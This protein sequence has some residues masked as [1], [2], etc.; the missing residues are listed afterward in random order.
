MR[1]S[2][3]WTL[4]ISI[5]LLVAGLLLSGYGLFLNMDK[6]VE[7]SYSN[8]GFYYYQYHTKVS[9]NSQ[10][11]L[12]YLVYGYL[13]FISGLATMGYFV[14]LATHPVE[15]KKVQAKKEALLKEAP[16]PHFEKKETVVENVREREERVHEEDV[17]GNEACGACKAEAEP[18]DTE[19]N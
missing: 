7:R 14:Y 10:L 1:T 2:A 13:I 5:V 19:A 17:S 15:K 6:I 18:V 9:G 4:A 16:Q 11:A 12:C 8:N 3:K